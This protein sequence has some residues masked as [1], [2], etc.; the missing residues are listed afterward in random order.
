MAA[1]LLARQTNGALYRQMNAAGCSSADLRRVSEAY[2][3]ATE[4]FAGAYR[5][6]GKPFVCH[7][8][9]TA[10]VIAQ[11]DPRIEPVLAALLH[12]AFVIGVFPDGT[13]GYSREHL[14]LLAARVGQASAD[15]VVDYNNFE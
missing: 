1:I 13:K 4:L 9:G 7:L 5:G 2:T 11:V 6:T 14:K 10:S 15:I 12:A 8:V 3:L